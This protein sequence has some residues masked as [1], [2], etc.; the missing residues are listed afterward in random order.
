M[1]LIGV[2]SVESICRGLEDDGPSI[3]VIVFE[4]IV[5]DATSGWLRRGRIRSKA[6]CTTPAESVPF[7]TYF[8][9]VKVLGASHEKKEGLTESEESDFQSNPAAARQ[10][11]D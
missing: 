4:P 1:G 8:S 6:F 5:I 3:E 9:S 7:A 10:S 2:V 11:S